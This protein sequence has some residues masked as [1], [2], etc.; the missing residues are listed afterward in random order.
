MQYTDIVEF[1]E[2]IQ[3]KNKRL[4]KTL[5]VSQLLK[6]CKQSDF[7]IVIPMMQGSVFHIW[8]ERKLG[9][10]TK[11][12][13]KA[14][15]L[16]TGYANIEKEWKKIGDLGEVAQ[17]LISNKKQS[18]LFSQNLTIKKVYDNIVKLST[19]SGNKSVDQKIKLISELY[20]CASPIEAKYITRFILE[21]MRI[22]VGE[23][24]IRD[25]I[26]WAFLDTKFLVECSK[27]KNIVPIEK[28]CIECEEKLE[29]IEFERE[30]YNKIINKL[31]EALD[32]SDLV[33]IAIAAKNNELHK[34]KIKVMKPV[35]AMLYPKAKNIEDAFEKL[36]K[37]MALEFKYDGFRLNV[38]K[39]ETVKLFT[40]SLEDVTEQFPDVVSY[41]DKYVSGD[42]FI[43]DCEVVGFKD[44]KYLPFQEI[45]QR[46]KRKYDIE[47]IAKK[48]PIIVNVFDILAFASQSTL[49]MPFSERRK[50]IKK[51]ISEQKGKIV[52]AE[53]LVTDNV[54]DAKQFYQKALDLGEEG[55]MAKKLDAIYKPGA[56]VGYGLKI[57]PVMETL[58]LVI[59]GAEWGTG[60]RANWLSSFSLACQKGDD[61]L[62]IGKV[63]TGFK[64]IG[65][66]LSFDEM[67]KLLKPLILQED[68]R[69]I[70]VKPK[71]IIEV[72]FEEIQKSTNYSSGFALR[73]PRVIRLR[74]DK[75]NPSELSYVK[76]L[77]EMQRGRG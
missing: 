69:E 15:N 35:K 20:S 58:D 11:Y 13:I 36:G 59:I 17:K 49:N 63:G 14:L 32:V 51:I 56:R 18:T 12:V 45:S 44:N 66:G 65:E 1:Y 10:S 4:A 5:Y 16:A 52:L 70:K 24:S 31:Q 42:N 3:A 6:K 72:Q 68:G 50:L 67:T 9:V 61:F 22:G 71:I 43:L 2:K 8:D 30:E 55:V 76:E 27:C 54:E 60:K 74:E 64:E 21:D 39:K 40:R 33:E 53:Q 47:E 28:K 57:K 26:A 75:N 29:K 46:I 7:N 34:I 62:E 41:I 38:H 77:Y 25:A 23:S 19:I 37:P 48:F 73:F